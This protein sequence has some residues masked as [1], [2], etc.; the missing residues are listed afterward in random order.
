VRLFEDVIGD[1]VEIVMREND[2]AAAGAVLQIVS[3]IVQFD[4]EV[5]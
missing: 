4:I 1:A 3:R 5:I 2:A